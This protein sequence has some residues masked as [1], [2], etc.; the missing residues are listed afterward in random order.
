MS[1]T[2]P[3]IVQNPTDKNQEKLSVLAR[4]ENLIA[5]IGK[6]VQAD[7]EQTLTMVTILNENVVSTTSNQPSTFVSQER[8]RHFCTPGVGIWI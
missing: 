3:V 8:S 5:E 7:F 1:V 4:S 6:V 2:Q